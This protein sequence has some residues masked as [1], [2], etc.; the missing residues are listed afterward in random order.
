M[1]LKAFPDIN[2]SNVFLG[3][4][5]KAIEIKAK[6]NNWDLIKRT[7]FCTAKETTKKMK[8][9]PTEW[10]KISANDATNKG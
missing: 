5:P 2:H 8:R 7:C 1:K 6:I 4:S 9:T 3:E 10:E